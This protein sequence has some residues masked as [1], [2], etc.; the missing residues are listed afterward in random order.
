MA[1]VSET[2]R[3]LGKTNENPGAD[4]ASVDPSASSTGANSEH[5]TTTPPADAK[6]KVQRQPQKRILHIF[7][8]ATTDASG[9]PSLEIV[10]VFSDARKVVEFFDSPASEGTKRYKYEVVSEPRGGSDTGEAS[11]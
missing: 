6:K 3:G 10:N 7:Y 11:E 1:N 9:Q 4:A 8:K 2:R 5:A